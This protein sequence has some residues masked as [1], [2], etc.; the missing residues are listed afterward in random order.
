MH[1]DARRDII[2]KF[3]AMLE[4]IKFVMFTTV[5]QDG[6]LHSRP[7][8]AQQ[9]GFDGTLWFITS[10]RSHKVDELR[11]EQHVNLA[12]SSSDDSRYVSVS[13]RAEV[14]RDRAK[15][16]ELWSPAHLAWFPKGKD[17]PD[18]ALVAV[19]VEEVEYWDSSQA[20]MVPL[21]GFTK[22]VFTGER[23]LPEEHKQISLD[24]GKKRTA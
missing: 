20:K 22:A 6:S 9:Q 10:R 21:I 11:R 17:D 15:I 24:P 1:A 12:Y 14:V 3:S 8:V 5:R 19:Q 16:D 7:M 13:G 4:G 2:Q 18:I 23:S